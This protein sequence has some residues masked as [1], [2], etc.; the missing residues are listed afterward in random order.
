MLLALVLL[1]VV[2]VAVGLQGYVGR[3]PS[4]AEFDI[5]LVVLGGIIVVAVVFVVPQLL[6]RH[7]L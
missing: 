6:R 3:P 4:Q 1:L 5:K 2:Y 7:Q